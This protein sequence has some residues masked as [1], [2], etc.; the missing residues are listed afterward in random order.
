MLVGTCHVLRIATHLRKAVFGRESY[1]AQLR[2]VVDL[3][4]AYDLTH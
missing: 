1:A 2:H 4:W 3:A